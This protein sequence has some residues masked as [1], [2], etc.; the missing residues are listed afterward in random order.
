[1]RLTTVDAATPSSDPVT[2]IISRLWQVKLRSVS[3]LEDWLPRTQDFNIRAGL[4]AH[5]AEER[6]HQRMLAAEIMRRGSRQAAMAVGTELDEPFTLVRDQ[7][8]DLGRMV[9]FHQGIKASCVVFALRV[10]PLVDSV[11]SPIL[12]QILHDEQRH[13]RW[14]DTRLSKDRHLLRREACDDALR[15]VEAAMDSLWR[16]PLTRLSQLARE[17]G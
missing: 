5:L 6:R 11:F 13:I 2:D 9:L 17:V 16:R 10:I 8:T 1:M 15:E 3:L 7:T 14:A 12:E 4:Q